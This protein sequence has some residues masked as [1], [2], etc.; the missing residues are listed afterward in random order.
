MSEGGAS[1]SH[2]GWPQVT[3][4]E[5]GK[6]ADK[7]PLCLLLSVVKS[8]CWERIQCIFVPYIYN[9]QT[10]LDPPGLKSG[11]YP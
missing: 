8:D 4:T 3:E 9:L 1:A 7:G 5:E 6:P 11:A 10:S 2:R